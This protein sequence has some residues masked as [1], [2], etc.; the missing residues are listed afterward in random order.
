[1]TA[2]DESALDSGMA[3]GSDAGG[4]GEHLGSGELTA[5]ERRVLEELTHGAPAGDAGRVADAAVPDDAVPDDAV[6]DGA[7]AD[8]AVVSAAEDE[9]P[10]PAEGGDQGDGL[11][12]PFSPPPGGGRPSRGVVG[13]R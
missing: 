7:V 10:L 2:P 8:D 4:P 12:V 1:M 13:G 5:D 3:S 11:S 9:T 6:P